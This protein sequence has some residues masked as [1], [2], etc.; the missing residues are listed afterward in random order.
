MHMRDQSKKNWGIACPT[1]SL[2]TVNNLITK[3]LRISDFSFVSVSG[4]IE[5]KS[6]GQ[7]EFSFR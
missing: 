6:N 2:I 4:S 1:G 7:G 3:R 5:A